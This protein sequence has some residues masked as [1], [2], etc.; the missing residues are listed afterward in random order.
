MSRLAAVHLS[1]LRFGKFGHLKDG[2]QSCLA[3]SDPQESE[4][5]KSIKNRTHI[6]IFRL[7]VQ[8]SGN[9]T[10]W[11]IGDMNFQVFP[12]SRPLNSNNFIFNIEI[13]FILSHL[14]ARDMSQLIL[15]FY[16]LSDLLS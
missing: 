3:Q 1:E 10:S 4:N 7:Y 15:L 5:L 14:V 8:D 13:I 6:K 12:K 9:V 2:S 16:T 11:R